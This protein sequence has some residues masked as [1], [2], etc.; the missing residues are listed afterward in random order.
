MSFKVLVV[1]DSNFFLQRLKEMINEH[2]ELD[3]IAMA[4][5]GREAVEKAEKLHPDIITM[6]FEMPVLN[7]VS[8]VRQI[9]AKNPIPIVMF[10][11]LTYEG[12]RVTL[13]ALEA[14]AVDFML[15]DFS[16]VS[17]NSISLKNHLHKNLLSI[18]Y[19]S[20]ISKGFPHKKSISAVTVKIVAVTKSQTVTPTA[21]PSF[22]L[23][24][25]SLTKET[26]KITRNSINNHAVLVSTNKELQQGSANNTGE[27]LVDKSFATVASNS[28]FASQSSKKLDNIPSGYFKSRI[29]LLVIGA[30]TGGPV[31]LM[32]VLTAL[33]ENFPVPILLVQHMPKNFTKAFAERLNRQCNIEVREAVDGDK[34][35]PGVALLATGGMQMMLDKQ[36]DKVRI[37]EADDR[38]NYKPSVDITFGSAANS[39]GAAVLGVVL[40]GMGTDGCEG[41][42]LLKEK[43]AM[44]WSQDKQSS[45]IYG[46]PM[47]VAKANLTDQVLSLETIGPQLAQVF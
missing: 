40:T 29:K 46:M 30:S 8:A 12:A 10:S 41:A 18:L 24:P 11:S 3:V 2:P 31:A 15:K 36:G 43:G 28:Q 32:D 45:I 22:T 44:I 7:G 37:L 38:V 34:L 35:Y 27:F 23:E 47:V 42:R 17:R 6:D 4:N 25:E 5:N 9:M 13:D 16:E 21:V 39:F 33:P 26:V 14:G 20:G 1:D 19:Q